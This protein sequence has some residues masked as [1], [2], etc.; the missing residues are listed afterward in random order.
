[1]KML[2]RIKSFILWILPKNLAHKILYKLVM[3]KNLNLKNPAD[4]N[5]K[6]QWLIVNKYG[7]SEGILADKFLVKD[8]V[9]KMNINGLYIPKTLK[10]YRD[11]NDINLD[12]LPDRFVIKCNHGSGKVF[13]CNNKDN[14]DIENAKKELNHELK[15][16]FAKLSLEYQYGFIKP[17][18]IAE[19]YLTDNNHKNPLDYKFYCFNGKV[20]SLLV[21]SNREKELKLDD[22]N[23]EWE[24]LDYTFEKFKSNENLQKPINFNNM[25]KIAED[26]AKV[27]NKNMPFVRIDL[28]NING[29]IYFGEYTFTPAAGMINYY[30]QSAL[31]ILG[32]KINLK[33]YSQN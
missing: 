1:M 6:I 31:N 7:S 18:I 26:L 3:K 16:N 28:Y 32:S 33:N 11:A 22:F 29:K 25:I 27:N 15:I 24:K 14:F 10:I 20:E 19:E 30:K 13:I 4:F 2:K 23:K 17:L 5:E 8:I 9:K 21:C 12:E